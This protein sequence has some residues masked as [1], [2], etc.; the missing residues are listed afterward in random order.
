MS[1]CAVQ[2]GQVGRC[3]VEKRKQIFPHLCVVSFVALHLSLT[4]SCAQEVFLD[5]ISVVTHKRA[6]LTRR[7]DGVDGPKQEF[8]EYGDP[9]LE[10]CSFMS[11]PQQIVCVWIEQPDWEPVLDDVQCTSFWRATREYSGI[12]EPPYIG[13]DSTCIWAPDGSFSMIITLSSDSIVVAFDT[14]ASSLDNYQSPVTLQPASQ[15]PPPQL[16]IDLTAASACE[17]AEMQVHVLGDDTQAGRVYEIQS[18]VDSLHTASGHGRFLSLPAEWLP[19]SGSRTFIISLINY[20]GRSQEAQATVQ[21]LGAT[22]AV[23]QLQSTACLPW[24]SEGVV[25]SSVV[26]SSTAERCPSLQGQPVQE[27]ETRFIV[28]PSANSS[29]LPAVGITR[30]SQH[31]V[32]LESSTLAAGFGLYDVNASLVLN[33]AELHSVA[34]RIC[35]QAPR[36]S[37]T[38]QSLAQGESSAKTLLSSATAYFFAATAES[39]YDGVDNTRVQDTFS[40]R[41]AAVSADGSFTVIPFVD[42]QG[43]LTLGSLDLTQEAQLRIS[44]NLTRQILSIENGELL[45]TQTATAMN[46][47]VFAE[48]EPAVA[49]T[50]TPGQGAVGYDFNDRQEP[51]YKVLQA[52]RLH[53]TAVESD[54]SASCEWSVVSSPEQV[55][56]LVIGS[57]SNTELVLAGPCA[58]GA[59]ELLISAQCRLGPSTGQDSIRIKTVQSILPGTLSVS[60]LRGIA[61]D[62]KFRFEF[63]GWQGVSGSNLAFSVLADPTGRISLADVAS[64]A[65]SSGLLQLTAET[66]VPVCSRVMLPAT[67]AAAQDGR[68]RLIG[69]VRSS[70][71]AAMAVD[72]QVALEEPDLQQAGAGEAL[73]SALRSEVRHLL[74]SGIG[75]GAITT[76]SGA[77]SVLDKAAAAT[78][79]AVATLLEAASEVDDVLSSMPS[80]GGAFMAASGIIGQIAR[81]SSA[82]LLSATTIA[83]LASFAEKLAYRS[84]RRGAPPLQRWQA[85]DLLAGAGMLLARRADPPLRMLNQDTEGVCNYVDINRFKNVTAAIQQALLAK[86]VN[87]EVLPPIAGGRGGF[88]LQVAKAGAGDA[89]VVLDPEGTYSTEVIPQDR[90]GAILAANLTSLCPLRTMPPLA[91][92]EAENATHLWRQDTT[93]DLGPAQ[94]IQWSTSSSSNAMGV[95][96]VIQGDYSLAGS[97]AANSTAVAT[98]LQVQCPLLN[99]TAHEIMCP[100]HGLVQP[101][102][103]G[104]ADTQ[105]TVRCPQVNKKVQCVALASGGTWSQQSCSTTDANSTHVHCTCSTNTFVSTVVVYDESALQVQPGPLT[106]ASTLL[107]QEPHAEGGGSI[108]LGIAGSI[109]ALSSVLLLCTSALDWGGTATFT[110]A[111]LLSPEV[112]LL[113]QLADASKRRFRVAHHLPPKVEAMAIKIGASM[114]P[115]ELLSST[116]CAPVFRCCLAVL[117]CCTSVARG[118]PAEAA[119]EESASQPGRTGKNKT[120]RNRRMAVKARASIYN[121]IHPRTPMRRRTAT[122]SV[123]AAENDVQAAASDCC[124]YRAPHTVRKTVL[125]AHHGLVY[126]DTLLRGVKLQEHLLLHNAIEDNLLTQQVHQMDPE[127]LQLPACSGLARCALQHDLLGILYN[128]DPLNPRSVRLLQ[129]AMVWLLMLWS[130]HH[131]STVVGYGAGVADNVPAI[132][133]LLLAHKVFSIGT[134]WVLQSTIVLCAAQKSDTLTS[135]AKRMEGWERLQAGWRAHIGSH[136]HDGN[137]PALPKRRLSSGGGSTKLRMDSSA[138]TLLAT[139]KVG[140]DKTSQYA[141]PQVSLPNRVRCEVVCCRTLRWSF[142]C[143]PTFVRRANAHAPGNARGLQLS[144]SSDAVA[145]GWIPVSAGFAK[146]CGICL[147]CVGRH[148]A[149]RRAWLR[150]RREADGEPY[151]CCWL[152]GTDLPRNVPVDVPAAMREHIAEHGGNFKMCAADEALAQRLQARLANRLLRAQ[153]RL[154]QSSCKRAGT[155]LAV[156]MPLTCSVVRRPIVGA[157]DPLSR[158]ASRRLRAAMERATDMELKPAQPCISRTV[159]ALLAAL[160]LT[161]ASAVA[162]S[163]FGDTLSEL[164]DVQQ[165]RAA[166]LVGCTLAL[167]YALLQPV[168]LLLTPQIAAWVIQPLLSLPISGNILFTLAQAYGF[169]LSPLSGHLRHVVRREAQAAACGMSPFEAAVALFSPLHLAILGVNTINQPSFDKFASDASKPLASGG[170]QELSALRT[171]QKAAA[172]AHHHHT[173]ALTALHVPSNPKEQASAHAGEAAVQPVLFGKSLARNDRRRNS[174]MV[175]MAPITGGTDAAADSKASPRSK[176]AAAKHAA[177]PELLGQQDLMSMAQ[178][179]ASRYLASRFGTAALEALASK[180][181]V[182]HRS[183]TPASRHRLYFG[184]GV[185]S[186]RPTFKAVAKLVVAMNNAAPRQEQGAAAGQP[187]AAAAPLPPGAAKQPHAS[188]GQN[189]TTVPRQLVKQQH[190]HQQSQAESATQRAGRRRRMSK[191]KP[192][193]ER[194][195]SAQAMLAALSAFAKPTRRITAND[196]ADAQGGD[197]TNA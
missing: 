123:K 109:I 3:L 141:V 32:R 196:A 184:D 148:P 80:S 41:C 77:V 144:D 188:H 146:W 57:P 102:Q 28:L 29:N 89:L 66:S 10:S 58:D 187:Q 183:D 147:R 149:Q 47:F 20:A 68:L 167:N 143:C 128:F 92:H 83:S 36:L 43:L 124:S 23:A 142:A 35:L 60:P 63:D 193:D 171:A 51:L 150:Q 175:V 30:E 113:K 97:P 81:S 156:S 69:L 46:Q 173:D 111:L 131:I 26:T 76:I 165:L 12:H 178:A 104:D 133:A 112:V 100:G 61:A 163:Q 5:D 99:T 115:T 122:P 22:L 160:L 101:C 74:S 64:G 59:S 90:H 154:T 180:Y 2:C 7:V 91:G 110:F 16:H 195:E 62:T 121:P 39:Q 116:L 65:V 134:W 181:A 18:D 31:S 25:L 130:A 78:D 11:D 127:P 197:A 189:N 6:P 145:Y 153:K 38:I 185:Q 172:G 159:G 9:Q 137:M 190:I 27:M 40:W 174:A 1:S 14:L 73:V 152:G 88:T 136:K 194:Q 169:V 117:S 79:A 157:S 107:E 84:L 132:A 170:V 95:Q 93:I 17:A 8:P 140:E 72:L 155:R 21:V 48:E 162:L 54:S 114:T 103:Q 42:N 119:Q 15:V 182:A 45:L 82:S 85:A 75:L 70:T 168:L 49:V 98:E 151:G 4:P 126:S 135:E 56:N 52:Q 164:S 19:L 24:Q 118:D 139:G 67:T 108:L 34:G 192:T 129:V 179:A 106:G 176:K 37:V 53:F 86:L 71:G 125:A 33:G 105:L 177:R 44:V 120:A 96:Y 94:A 158:L 191:A 50:V 55:C 138:R 13:I 166:V 186:K 87:G 161:V